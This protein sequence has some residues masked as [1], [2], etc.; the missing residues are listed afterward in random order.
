[1][2]G[3][4]ELVDYTRIFVEGPL[5]PQKKQKLKDEITTIIDFHTGDITISILAKP[6]V[7]AL[8]AE[9]LDKGKKGKS[10]K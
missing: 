3:K 7:S 8:V 2:S 9:E 1:M 4:G 10:K 5:N 6:S